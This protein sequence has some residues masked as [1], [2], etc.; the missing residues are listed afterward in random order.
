M[1]TT[2]AVLNGLLPVGY[3]VALLGYVV[4][5]VRQEGPLGRWVT[6]FTRGV[7]AVHAV[8][9]VMAGIEYEHLPLAST[10]ESLT[11]TAFA[12]ALVYLV[13]EWQMRDRSTGS[14]LLTIVL[15]LQ[16]LSTAFISHTREVPAI[17]RSPMYGIHVSTALL[18]Y[19]ALAVSAVY[20][21][22]YLIQYR[23][24]KQRHVGLLF[25]RLPN[26]ET[27]SRLN[28][29]ALAIGW[30]GLTVAIVAGTIWAFTL[31][32]AGQ[33]QVNLLQDAKFLMTAGLWVV[34]GACLA[35][36]YLLGW[37]KRT[38]ASVS[39]VAFLLMLGSSL[40]V[41]LLFPSFHDFS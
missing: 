30:L 9:L 34:Y 8:Y 36:L 7:V 22:M 27:L 17:L 14:F 35:G 31:S 41:T 39:V 20:G 12:V 26:L 1:E 16:I 32:R 24:L 40:M 15:L 10:W 5:F 33:L 11:F 38:L 28:V 23:Q 6:A 29:R 25:Q 2:L 13:L 21:I 3:L 37:A 19:V 4:V 18:G